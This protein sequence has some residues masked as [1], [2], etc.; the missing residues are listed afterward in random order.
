MHTGAVPEQ[1][2]GGALEIC[3]LC[4]FDSSHRVSLG[5]PGPLARL[6]AVRAWAVTTNPS[7]AEPAHAYALYQKPDK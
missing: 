2:K 4:V 3:L 6:L 1:W 7:V 5:H